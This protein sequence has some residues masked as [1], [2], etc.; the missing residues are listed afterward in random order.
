L[1]KKSAIDY[2]SMADVEKEGAGGANKVVLLNDEFA[3]AT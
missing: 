3:S 2:S 1:R